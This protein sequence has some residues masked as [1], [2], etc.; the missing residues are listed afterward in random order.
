MS[1]RAGEGDM[2]AWI[3]VDAFSVLCF[4]CLFH[5]EVACALLMQKTDGASNLLIDEKSPYLLQHAGN[6][7]KWYPWGE[8]AFQKSQEGR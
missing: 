8:E 1:G 2:E 4:C 7:V 6:P 3:L 5:L